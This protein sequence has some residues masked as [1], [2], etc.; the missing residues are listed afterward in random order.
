MKESSILRLVVSLLILGI[1]GVGESISHIFWRVTGGN[2]TM[3][4]SAQEVLS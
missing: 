2:T 4:I 3:S 1:G